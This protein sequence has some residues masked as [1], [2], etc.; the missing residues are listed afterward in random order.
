MRGQSIVGLPLA[1]LVGIILVAALFISIGAVVVKHFFSTDSTEEAASISNVFSL[2][3]KIRDQVKNPAP[4]VKDNPLLYVGKDSILVGFTSVQN[5]PASEKPKQQ[6]VGFCGGKLKWVSRPDECGDS[7]CLCLYRNPTFG[8]G[9]DT[10]PVAC[11]Q[12][13]GVDGVF[14]FWYQASTAHFNNQFPG[15]NNPK[16]LEL[17][18]NTFMGECYPWVAG[19]RYSQLKPEYYREIFPDARLFANPPKLS[20]GGQGTDKVNQYA[21]LVLYGDCSDS[22]I[23]DTF[24]TQTIYLEKAVLDGKTNILVS[25]PV[26]EETAKA[27]A[28]KVFA[29]IARDTELVAAGTQD[30]RQAVQL[31]AAY[32]D[33]AEKAK[34]P[35]G[36]IAR[37]KAQLYSAY[38]RLVQL[39]TISLNERATAYHYLLDN[40]DNSVDN[41]NIYND[42]NTQ[43]S[44]LCNQA[45]TLVECAGV[46]TVETEPK[47]EVG[48]PC[49]GALQRCKDGSVFSCANG[50]WSSA[51]CD[52]LCTNVYRDNT[53]KAD[54]A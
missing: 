5:L 35:V 23:S 28:E 53:L 17:A 32:V 9:L 36:D 3:A 18:S 34:L 40:Y 6:P 37:G 4:F 33:Y 52:E 54:C 14:S 43:L 2:A 25:F 21:S 47:P 7:A 22:P 30:A 16:Q 31:Y 38:S 27:R 20:C 44:V 45:R 29:A 19:T 24:Q 50:I 39:S 10:L 8:I 48:Q 46:P 41:L 1:E 49:T 12:L 42:A 13:P 15:M 51:A 26:S 11:A